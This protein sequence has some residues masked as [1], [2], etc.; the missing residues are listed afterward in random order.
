MP[1]KNVIDKFAGKV[2][3]Y[4]GYFFAA[5][6]HIDQQ[7]GNLRAELT[8]RGLD[9]NTLIL[10]MTD[11]G[12]TAGV[13]TFNAGMR[14]DKGDVYEGGHRVPL[15]I[16]WP[17]GGI[18]EG[19]DV[20]ALTAHIDVLPTL[21][22]LLELEVTNPVVFDGL[23]L[24]SVLYSDGA[25]LVPRTLFV[26]AQRTFESQAWVNTAAMQGKWRLVNNTELY[27]LKDDPGQLDNIIDQNSVLVAQLRAAHKTYWQQVTPGDRDIPRHIVGHPDDPETFLSP[28]DWHAPEV[29]WHHAHIAAGSPLKGG[30]SLNVAKKG[31]Y[32][33]QVSRW[34]KEAKATM[35]GIPELTKEVD[36]WDDRGGKHALIYG[37]KFVPL[38]IASVKL[39]VG[40]EA[41]EKPVTQH[42]LAVQF[43]VPLIQGDTEIKGYFLDKSGRVISGAYYIYMSLVK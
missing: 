37:D 14:G 42:T 40:D 20:E 33:I 9:E 34:P 41:W 19:K 2:N 31:R 11:N 29:P 21:M 28:S 15:F 17:T 22:D 6:E 43:D 23:S 30:W 12:G 1:D 13:Q 26:E 35:Q 38:P 18:S 25:E 10:F 39:I 5:I 27:N 16:H 36:A 3:P 32:Q 7:I 4:T 24:K 8:K